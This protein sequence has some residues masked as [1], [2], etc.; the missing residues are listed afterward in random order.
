MASKTRMIVAGPDRFLL[1]ASLLLID[2][3]GGH[4]E[5]KFRVLQEPP[6]ETDEICVCIT[7]VRAIDRCLG[8]WEFEG[9]LKF[10]PEVTYSGTYSTHNRR[11]SINW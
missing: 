3:T 10:S 9:V 6:Q 1:A 5:V 8:Q 2:S 7:S 11:G 4:P